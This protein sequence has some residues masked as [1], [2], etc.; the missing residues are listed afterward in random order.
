MLTS[1]QIK[2]LGKIEDGRWL[3]AFK[4]SPLLDEPASTELRTCIAALADALLE[5]DRL[6]AFAGDALTA[7]FRGQVLASAKTNGLMEEYEKWTP[8][9]LRAVDAAL[10][11]IDAN[12]ENPPKEA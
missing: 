5:R 10:A 3:K 6:L 7:T 1:E 9:G 8:L 2:V 12:G 4:C 11:W